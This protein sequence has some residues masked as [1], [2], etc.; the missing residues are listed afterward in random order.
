MK[1]KGIIEKLK[2]APNLG[3]LSEYMHDV[4]KNWLYISAKTLRKAERTA[5]A[6]IREL[7]K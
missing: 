2:S 6:R 3:V 1:T 7:A 4:R 5:A